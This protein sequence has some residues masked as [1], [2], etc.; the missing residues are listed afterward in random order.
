[1]LSIP[2]GVS[3]TTPYSTALAQEIMS[4]YYIH[5][6][7]IPLVNPQI[8]TSTSVGVNAEPTNYDGLGNMARNNDLAIAGF[9]GGFLDPNLQ[10][11]AAAGGQRIFF[12][13]D[14]AKITNTLTGTSLNT[15]SAVNK[16]ICNYYRPNN[17]LY[18]G[19]SD[20]AKA[21]TEYIQT[22]H[23]LKVDAAV[24]AA[25]LT[26]GR[27][28]LNG[29]QVFGGD[30]FINIYDRVNS[31]YNEDYSGMYLNAGSYSWAP[32]FPC[33][34]QINSALRSGR[35]FVADGLQNFTNGIAYKNLSGVRND[36]ALN[37]NSSYS[38][39]ND[40]IKYPALPIGFR[41]VNRFPYMVRYSEFKNLGEA[42]DNMRKYLIGNFR[43]VDALHGE[44]N[45]LIVGGEKL[46]Y[47]QRRGIGYIP[48]E[49]RQLVGGAIGQSTQLGVGGVA[50]R[51][52][53]I[54]KFY[55]CQH[56]SSVR[57]LENKFIF[58]DM[59]RYSV[60]SFGFSG[61]V[62]DTSVMDGLQTFFQNAFVSAQ[63]NAS[64]IFNID[65]P[66]L[67]NGVSGVYDPIKKTAYLTFKFSD[68]NENSLDFTI[69]I[70]SQ[71]GKFIG[72]FSFV[73]TIYA[74][75]NSRVY[76]VNVNRNIIATST[77][78]NIG[79]EISKDGD[80]YVCVLGFTT[81]NPVAAGEQPDS[82]G[83]PYWI[84]S[85]SSN[86]VHRMFTGDICKYFGV[87]Y[88]HYIDI[89]VN[90]QISGQKSFDHAESYG[91]EVK[92]TDVICN[93]S[94]N[95]ASDLNITSTNK[96][97]RF[98]DGKWN[99]SY[100]LYR[101]TKRLTDEYMIVRLQIKN[102]S[103]NIITSLNLQKRLVYLKTIFRF[104]K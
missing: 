23:Y 90:P 8:V 22:G 88:P 10:D 20:N 2:T 59:S 36:E 32:T 53:T 95:T 12:S 24:K 11:K 52:D 97:Y 72:Y 48:V 44:I 68:E 62:E 7:C 35:R 45:N 40:L 1:M 69:G 67:G 57:V 38:T 33:E 71:I 4:K 80:N 74:E 60:I 94:D 30:T 56:Q 102:W 50:Q 104:R 79:N 49:E 42:T 21:N 78:Y 87:V 55:G 86:E 29:I 63:N 54:D 81:S 85:S 3:Y 31:L 16:F 103:V 77:V 15:Q 51:Y 6:R 61:V 92:Y 91:N 25:I 93:T 76:A 96:N 100:P 75:I 98:Y 82:V 9:T 41:N 65:Q 46:F 89:V 28:V 66:L 58:W 70:A 18:G 43:N 64:A 47:L 13:L 19:T 39:E 37:Y 34:S 17:N 5:N 83:S 27:Y 84:K 73:P 101:N 26:G 14:A 99:F